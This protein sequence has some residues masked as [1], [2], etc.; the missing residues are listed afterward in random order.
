[1]KILK[2]DFF[3]KKLENQTANDPNAY[4]LLSTRCLS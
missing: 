3:F 1:M 2:F 4:N